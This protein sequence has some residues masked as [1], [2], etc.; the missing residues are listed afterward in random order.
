MNSIVRRGVFLAAALVLP[1]SAAAQVTSS[2][3]RPYYIA[4]SFA[5][6]GGGDT[7]ENSPA[8]GIAAGWMGPR[9]VGIE[10]ELAWTPGFFE[11]D[12]FRIVRRMRT[13]MVSGL[14]QL[15]FGAGVGL[16][17]YGAAG[18]GIV[19]PHLTDAGEFNDFESTE[20]GYNAGGGVMWVKRGVG[21]RGDVRYMRI[22]G[23]ATP[24]SFGV[25]LSDYGFWRVSTGLV[26][27]F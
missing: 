24:N 11:Q 9:R 18:F 6:N 3:S 15:P 13:F 23:D 27:K 2:Y 21:L 14:V 8:V 4:P 25:D 26:V 10:G 5:L 12:G 19:R 16:S 20:P 22:A 1:A 7:V 17:P